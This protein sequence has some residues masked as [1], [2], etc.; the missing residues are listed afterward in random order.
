MRSSFVSIYFFSNSTSICFQVDRHI[1][2]IPNRIYVIMTMPYLIAQLKLGK[3]NQKWKRNKKNVWISQWLST[4]SL[5]FWAFIVGLHNDLISLVWT[6]PHSVKMAYNFV[7]EIGIFHKTEVSHYK[8]LNAPDKCNLNEPF[9]LDT[10]SYQPIWCNMLSGP[11]V[12]GRGR[13]LPNNFEFTIHS[14]SRPQICILQ[15]L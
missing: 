8:D 6:I 3:L 14:L 9:S 11:S 5:Q 2:D 13:S 1:F 15:P 7:Q 12:L 10:I 4:S